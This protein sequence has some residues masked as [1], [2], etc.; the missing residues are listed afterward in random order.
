MGLSG[1][2]E[3]VSYRIRYILRGILYD[4][5][6]MNDVSVILYVRFT[7]RRPSHLVLYIVSYHTGLL[8][9]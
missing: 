7:F 8:G 6:I 1:R 2:G 4:A 9:R 3:H 5:L